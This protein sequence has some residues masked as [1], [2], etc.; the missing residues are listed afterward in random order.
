MPLK[1]LKEVNLL[2]Y[3]GENTLRSQKMEEFSGN[4]LTKVLEENVDGQGR[5]LLSLLK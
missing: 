2:L 1:E 3:E 5:P 4:K